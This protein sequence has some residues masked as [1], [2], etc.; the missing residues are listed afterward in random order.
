MFEIFLGENL[1]IVIGATVLLGEEMSLRLL[2]CSLR[3]SNLF[4]W[5][6]VSVSQLG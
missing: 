1:K 3:V 4:L 6:F 2:L 5:W